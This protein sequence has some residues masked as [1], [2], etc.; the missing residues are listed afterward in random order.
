MYGVYIP[1]VWMTTYVVCMYCVLSV[2]ACVSTTV[3][4]THHTYIQ[5]NPM[6]KMKMKRYDLLAHNIFVS[7]MLNLCMYDW[8]HL[9]FNE[10]DPLLDNDNGNV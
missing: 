6:T 2:C 3:W 8:N 1:I 4:M 10:I 5:S 9:I 7:L